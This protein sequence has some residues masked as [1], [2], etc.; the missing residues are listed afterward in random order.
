MSSAALGGV[1]WVD[2]AFAALL[3]L[4]TVVGLWR[5][6]LFEVMSL[7]GWVAAYVAA[8]AF[9][10][11]LAPQLPFGASGSALQLGA[12]FAIVF[13]LALIV[14]SLLSSLL[15]RLMQASPLSGLDRL[16]GAVFGLLRGVLIGVVIATLVQLTP[17]GKS[18]DW[19]TSHGAAAMQT[20]LA[21]L[22][23]WL[24]DAVVKHLPA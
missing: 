5:G 22:R 12:A 8:Q 23:P 21:G 18:R 14:W 1:G 16:F 6:L 3:L 13:V 2:L 20:V 4:S 7:L 10:P 24:P 17:F 9:A 19:R 15:R 11:A